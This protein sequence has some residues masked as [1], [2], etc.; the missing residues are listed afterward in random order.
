MTSNPQATAKLVGEHDVLDYVPANP[1]NS[2]DVV[3]LAGKAG[4]VLDYAKAGEPVG[5]DVTRAFRFPNP[6]LGATVGTVYGWDSAAKK[7]VAAGAGD[8]DLGTCIP[9]IDNQASYDAGVGAVI[10]LNG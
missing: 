3:Q 9:T 8:F 5:I 10:A 6:D 4:V 2:G 7:I 1:V